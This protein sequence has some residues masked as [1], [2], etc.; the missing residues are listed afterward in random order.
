MAVAAAVFTSFSL[1]ITMFGDPRG[2][3]VLAILTWSSAVGA[4][5]GA[6]SGYVYLWARTTDDADF[7]GIED[8]SNRE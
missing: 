8:L 7:G 5:V 6:A 2:S 1:Y 4:T 3:I